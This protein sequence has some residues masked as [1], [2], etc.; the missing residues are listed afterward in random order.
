[1]RKIYHLA[2]CTTCQRILKDFGG[3]VGTCELQ[4]I[5]EQNLT[6]TELDFLK[7]KMGSYESLFSRKALKFRSLGLHEK[8]LTE[9]DYR[10]LILSE[11]TFLKRPVII[12]GAEV[13]VGNLSKTVAA[14]KISL[15][16]PV[17]Q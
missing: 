8:T 7:E 16:K 14:A 10:E 3:T 12:N 6:A 4:N 2:N 13:F 1:M 11:H 5:K 15:E 9:A 17:G